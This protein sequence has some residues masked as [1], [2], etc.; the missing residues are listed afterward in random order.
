MTRYLIDQYHPIEKKHSVSRIYKEM[1][2]I[3]KFQ[4]ATLENFKKGE[5][6]FNNLFYLTQ[7]V[8][9]VIISTTNDYKCIYVIFDTLSLFLK[10]S[11]Y[12]THPDWK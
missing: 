6:N 12:L 4:V 3:W 8:L 10:F 9:N 5:I 2:V 11:L 7:Y 1:H